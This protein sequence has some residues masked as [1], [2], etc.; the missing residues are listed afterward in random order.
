VTRHAASKM[1]TSLEANRTSRTALAS[2]G[3]RLHYLEYGPRFDLQI[4]VVCLP[5]LTRSAEDFDRIARVLAA[6]PNGRGRRVL[7]LDYRGRGRSDWDPDWTHYN[8]QVEHQ[9]ILA[10]L[11]AAEVTNAIFIGTSRG[12]LHIMMLGALQPLLM[13]GA[14]INDIGPVVEMAGVMRIKSY[15]GKLPPLSSWKDAIDLLR[16]SACA[17]FTDVSRED[18]ETY[19][20]QTFAEEG[21]RFALRYDPALART[22]DAVTVDAPMPPLWPQFEAL[23]GIPVLGIRGENSDIL[24]PETFA[25]MG[26][27]H[28]RFEACVVKGQGHAPLLLDAPTISAIAEFVGRIT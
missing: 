26:R 17:Y 27:R 12:G 21:G 18:W 10:T 25:E 28:P 4:P 14:V 5:G 2:D 22:L 11:A 7:A 13:R 24:S 20:R 9:D 3:L 19:A 23:A 6:A 1:T 8:L 16:K 15:V